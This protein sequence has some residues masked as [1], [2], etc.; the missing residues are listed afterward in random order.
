MGYST[1]RREHQMLY[2][3]YI[4]RYMKDSTLNFNP[5]ILSAI[6]LNKNMNLKLVCQY[7]ML[8]LI[9][10]SIYNINITKEIIKDL[11]CNYQN[12]FTN[13]SQRLRAT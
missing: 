11:F 10:S 1:K 9:Y 8:T 12:I 3:W 2:L 6:N 4:L 5:A 7:I 13:N